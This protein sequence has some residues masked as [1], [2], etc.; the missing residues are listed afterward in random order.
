L[1]L[2]RFTE[3][4]IGSLIA[5]AMAGLYVVGEGRL[6]P[7]TDTVMQLRLTNTRLFIRKTVSVFVLA[8]ALVPL[9]SLKSDVPSLA[10]AAG[11]VL[12]HVLVVVVYFYRVRVRELDPDW[13]SLTVRVL[14]LIFVGY[15]LYALSSFDSESSLATLGWQMFVLSV[16]HTLALLLLMVRVG[17][18]TP[19]EAEA[20]TART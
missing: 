20:A 1:N 19:D 10:Y 3:I 12:L 8:L 7:L 6:P 16:L 13:R 11:L 14:A 15:M 18:P 4:R 2:P 5:G 17:L 9:V